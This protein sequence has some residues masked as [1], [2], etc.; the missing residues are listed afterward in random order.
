VI[1]IIALFAG[2]L[3]PNLV[4]MKSSREEREFWVALARFTTQGRERAI[5]LGRTVT[6]QFDGTTNTLT[7]T[8]INPDDGL[9]EDLAHLDLYEGT[10]VVKFEADDQ[11]LAPSEWKLHFYPESKADKGGLE[12]TLNNQTRALTVDQYGR[13]QVI[14]GQLPD[15]TDDKWTA[16]DIEHRA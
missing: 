5:Q 16:G 4:R 12:L 3:M 2:L 7:F 14:E 10:Q 15:T 6:M 9:E 1:V 13:A 8:S 11:Q